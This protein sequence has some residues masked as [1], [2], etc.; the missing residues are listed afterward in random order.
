MSQS[1]G[2]RQVKPEPPAE[3]V[4]FATL[5]HRPSVFLCPWESLAHRHLD[6]LQATLGDR[7]FKE[8]D[9]VIESSGGNIHVAYQIVEILR[10]HTERIFACVP[11]YAKSAATLLCLGADEIVMERLAELGPL[12]TQ[13]FE[14]TKGKAEFTSA[15]NP[16]KALEQLQAFSLE[17]LDASV[18]MLVKRSDLSLNE[19][20]K[21]AIEFAVGTTN[22]LFAQLDPE[23]LGEYS[24]ALAIGSEYGDRL[25]RRF[26]NWD[27]VRRAD[28]LNKLVHGYPSH[29]Y[30]IDYRELRELG[31]NVKLLSPDETEAVG[32]A[33]SAVTQF[34]RDTDDAT[35]QLILLV[36]PARSTRKPR[37]N[38]T[39]EE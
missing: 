20:I 3:L 38:N 32:K 29:D 30:I 34:L 11:A 31:L 13:V 35:G 21:H 1:Q 36:E 37:T 39:K 14:D 10:L 28:V 4:E 17:A 8:V 33:M 18:K 5:R 15:L 25:L 19:C 9:L 2:Q 6:E 7:R 23:K 24:R 16:F 22:P 12:D 27:P 26:A